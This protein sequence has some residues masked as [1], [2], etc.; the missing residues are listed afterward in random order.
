MRKIRMGVVGTSGIADL[1]V[2]NA[3]KIEGL[4]IT[5]VYSR[6]KESGEN[7]ALKNNINNVFIDLELMAKSNVI[8]AVYIAS[9]NALHCSQTLLMLNNK[10]HVLC[11]KA[12]ASNLEEVK[13]MVNT[14][15]QNGVIL[16]E[17]MRTTMLPNFKIVKDNLYK[18]GKV[19]R[20]FASYCQYSSRYDS[21]KDGNVQNAFKPELSNGGIMDIGVYTLAP[22]VSLFGMPKE[23][24][25][26]AYMLSSGVDGE[27]TI[28][29]KYDDMEAVTMYSKISNSYIP[30]EIQGEEGSIIINKIDNFNEV[31]IIYKDGKVEDLS[32][33]QIDNG[34]YYEI[35]HFADLIEDNKKESD[36]N[37]LDFSKQLMA[38]VDK[39]RQDIGLVFP[40]DLK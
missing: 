19:R 36:I 18:I 9:P 26:S 13:V 4:E 34:M 31:K 28:I 6:N 5:A 33:S 20:Y 1:F 16:M 39:T 35:K 38:V 25:A 22:M 8:D 29:C 11:E 37:S 2:S 27:G 10:K 14:A 3:K 17:A 30:S 32:V 7:F 15:K 23:V 24:K 12:L 21:F 40:S